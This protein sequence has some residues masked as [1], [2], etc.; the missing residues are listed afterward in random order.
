MRYESILT[1]RRVLWAAGVG[2]AGFIIGGIGAMTR[3]S[4]VGLVWGASIGYGFGSIFDQRQP[5]MWLVVYWGF[6]LSLIGPFFG[7]VIGAKPD[8]SFSDQAVSGGT[9]AA[10]GMVLG[11]IF[12]AI[13]RSRL[14]RVVRHV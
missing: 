10:V 13:H 12:G 1:I 14:R 5:T 4:A 11:L 6:T 8:Y 2:F 9:G 3:G 7:L